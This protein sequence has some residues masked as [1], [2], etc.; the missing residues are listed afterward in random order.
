MKKVFSVI[1]FHVGE[2]KLLA[3]ALIIMLLMVTSITAAPLS[4]PEPTLMDKLANLW[5]F[6]ISLAIFLLVILWY[7]SVR[8]STKKNKTTRSRGNLTIILILGMVVVMVVVLLVIPGFIERARVIPGPQETELTAAPENRTELVLNVDGM[9][10]TG[11]EMAIQNRVAELQGV[12]SVESNHI[13]R[14][15]VVV[16]DSTITD[17]LSI[18]N[19][20][21]QAG[22]KV[23]D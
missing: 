13:Q 17:S 14:T 16:F 4:G 9:T 15:T 7:Q 19:A 12:E 18:A 2:L 20:I 8:I 10:C 3:T 1:R 23:L 5:P 22:Y 11:C 6:I 21:E